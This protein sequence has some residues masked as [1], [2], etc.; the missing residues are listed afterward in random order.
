V[1]SSSKGLS[2][3]WLKDRQFDGQQVLFKRNLSI[4][5]SL[6]EII[7][8]L[9]V[10]VALIRNG[11]CCIKDLDLFAGSVLYDEK[12]TSLFYK[13]PEPYMSK[14]APLDLMIGMAQFY[15][16]VSLVIGGYHMMR[17]GYG[18]KKACAAVRSQIHHQRV[19]K[20]SAGYRVIETQ[21][22]DDEAES[23]RL[24]WEGIWVTFVGGSFFWLT[25]NSLHLIEAGALGG[26]QGLIHAI[27]V[28]EIALLVSLGYMV[29]DGSKKLFKSQRISKDVIPTLTESRGRLGNVVQTSFFDNITYS[30][31][32]Y[33]GW[34]PVWD[35]ADVQ[36]IDDTMVQTELKSIQQTIDSLLALDKSAKSESEE[37]LVQAVTLASQRL[38]KEAWTIKMKGYLDYLYF[39]LNAVAFYGY[40]ICVLVFYLPDKEGAPVLWAHMKYGLPNPVADWTGNFAGDAMWTIEPFTML[41]APHIVSALAPTANPQKKKKD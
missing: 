27:T 6:I 39:I 11:L 4:I 16:C 13:L 3:H 35:T 29:K 18:T 25:A 22:A 24:M 19:K 15:A 14:T 31:L 20:Y 5:N 9:N 7:M 26:M 2:I 34:T 21:L 32:V 33:G 23:F 17:K 30:Q 41:L 8:N 38:S 10:V 28:A 36:K 37:K 40:L 1:V 12:Y